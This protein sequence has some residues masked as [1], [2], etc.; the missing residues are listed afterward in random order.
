MPGRTTNNDPLQGFNRGVYRF[1]DAVDRAALKPVAKGYQKITPHWL[2]VGVS[3][4]FNNLEQ[5]WTIVNEL[6][7]GKPKAMA[8]GTCRFV[9]NSVIGVAG[10]VDIASRAG[11]PLYEEDFGQTLAVWGLPSGPYVMLP[12][13]G[14]SSVRDA[15]AKVIDFLARP[16]RYADIPWEADTAIT[17]VNVIDTRSKLLSVEGTL[18]NAYDRYGVIRDVWVQQREYRIY[19]GNPPQEKIEDESLEDAAP[20]P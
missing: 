5:P 17:T 16:Q 1:N 13:F 15:P 6:L 2:R 3:N 7:Q 8:Q 20:P 12:L 14:P 10:F 19:D 18:Q 11:L 9:L 4:F